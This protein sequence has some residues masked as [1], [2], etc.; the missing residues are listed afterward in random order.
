MSPAPVPPA[1]RDLLRAVALLPATGAAVVAGAAAG[2][3]P[4][5]RE[6]ALRCEG[7]VIEAD[8]AVCALSPGTAAVYGPGTR[9]RASARGSEAASRQRRRRSGARLPESQ[10]AGLADD[11]LADLLALTGPILATQGQPPTVFPTGAVVAGPVGGWRYTWPRDASFAAAAFSAV[12]LR[13]EALAVLAHLAEV[14]RPDGGFEAR[15]TASGGVPDSR[16]AQGDGAGWMLWAAGRVMADGAGIDELGTVCG[17]G[18]VRAVGNL[19]ALTDTPS[20]LPPSPG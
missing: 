3:H 2:S 4:W 13:D 18:L 11:A 8:G 1:R 19:M 16:P 15:Y 20:H 17:A 5:R 7:V 12:G 14:Q 6:P 9:V 10:W